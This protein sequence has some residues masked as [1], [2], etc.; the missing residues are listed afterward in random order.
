[1]GIRFETTYP[2]TPRTVLGV[3][4]DRRFV[5]ACAL[6]VGALDHCV[7]VRR[8]R[9]RWQVD[10]RLL[11]STGGAPSVLQVVLGDSVTIDVVRSWW[12]HGRRGY[13]G[14]WQVAAIAGSTSVVVGGTAALVRR[15]HGVGFA[16]DADVESLSL[17]ALLQPWAVPGVEH[18]CETALANEAA[19]ARQ[20]LTEGGE[21]EG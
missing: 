1:V 10:T 15:A 17:P 3:L 18:V 8:E 6:A 12:S 19:L 13:A 20:W 14:T 4:T 21:A 9:G 16:A 2:T 7:E 5:V 11:V